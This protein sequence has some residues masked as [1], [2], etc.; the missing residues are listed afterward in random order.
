LQPA[1]I[2]LHWSDASLADLFRLLRGQD[3]GV[4]GLSRD[5]TAKSG[6]ARRSI[7][8]LDIFGPGARGGRSI[9]GLTE[10]SDNPRVNANV[11]G[12]WNGAT[13]NVVAEQIV[14]EGPKIE[15]AREV[16]T[17][18]RKRGLDGITA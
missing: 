5:A 4:R 3:Y 13:G 7:R 10:R 15:S 12:R 14:L 18:R 9:V 17:G 6:I 16:R 2:E 8:G 11:K 1:E